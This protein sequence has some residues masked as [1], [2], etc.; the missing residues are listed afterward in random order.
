MKP[1]LKIGDRVA[2]TREHLKLGFTDDR[3]T[4]VSIFESHPPRVMVQWDSGPA[5]SSLESNLILAN[6]IHLET[7]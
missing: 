5:H 1:Q 2:W 3:G 4:V 7:P 6:R